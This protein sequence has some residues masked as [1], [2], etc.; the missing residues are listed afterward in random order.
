MITRL[1]DVIDDCKSV[2]E[3]VID[4]V[5]DLLALRWVITQDTWCGEEEVVLII[6]EVMFIEEL[7]LEDR[8][9]I[10]W[11]VALSGVGAAISNHD[12]F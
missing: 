10:L 7:H 1:V 8:H 6:D 3:L 5:E 9:E 4:F 11:F 2:S 12:S